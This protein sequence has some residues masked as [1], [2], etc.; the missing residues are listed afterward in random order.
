M[1]CTAVK[2]WLRAREVMGR[3]GHAAIS[4]YDMGAM[5]L[6]GY[7][8]A[9]GWL[10]LH[11]PGSSN[12]SI[13]QF[14][15]NNCGKKVTARHNEEEELSD[16]VELG[17][18]K[19]ALR[20]LKEALGLVHPWNK[21]VAALDGFLHM[22]NFCASDLA[23]LDKQAELLSQF[24]D[25]VLRENSNKWR[26]QE[27]FLQIGELRSTWDSFFGGRPQSMLTKAKKQ[28]E[29]EKG[30]TMKTNPPGGQGF[31]NNNNKIMIPAALWKDDICVMWNIGKCLKPPGA[32]ETKAGR[33]LRHVCNFRPD[34]NKNVACGANHAAIYFHR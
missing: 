21:S 13:R 8:T 17:E 18:F 16:V 6:A 31:N 34:L 27:A 28:R 12:L 20:A 1:G 22:T 19:V 5:G 23:G 7:V 32:C 11:D 24:T 4:T 33:P 9:R 26:G 29:V 30:T 10:E 15:I 3:G 25:Y 2:T 14:S